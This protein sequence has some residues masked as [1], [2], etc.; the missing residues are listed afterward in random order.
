M[1]FKT[2]VRS[3]GASGGARLTEAIL[4]DAL[5]GACTDDAMSWRFIEAISRVRAL[6]QPGG[7]LGR[8][9]G[10]YHEDFCR[11]TQSGS[12][13]RRRLEA[14]RALLPAASW[15]EPPPFSLAAWRPNLVRMHC[16]TR[17]QR[18]HDEQTMLAIARYGPAY[19]LAWTDV[20]APLLPL[21]RI[22]L[23]A[24][25]PS[26]SALDASIEAA[27]QVARSVYGNLRIDRD[28]LDYSAPAA[29]W[30]SYATA[31]CEARFVEEPRP[32]PVVE[33]ASPVPDWE[34]EL[35]A[36]YGLCVE[37][38]ARFASE[39]PDQALAQL[40]F[41]CDPPADHVLVS[42]DT[43]D[44]FVPRRDSMEQA[45]LA[46]RR[47]QVAARGGWRTA[48]R[49]FGRVSQEAHDPGNFEHQFF[50]EHQVTGLDAYMQAGAAPPPREDN[51]ESYDRGKLRMLFFR[52]FDRMVTDGVLARYPSWRPFHLGY[53]FH[54]ET[55][56]I[57]FSLS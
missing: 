48:H 20:P 30:S 51:E 38:L 35:E 15:G 36:L 8:L 5:A 29:L 47:R 54:S 7:E 4:V 26:R 13:L 9:L 43:A 14:L 44:D 18:G 32:D 22:P 45:L 6:A 11:G 34:R 40:V 55:P 49:Y 17:S 56:V 42:L 28:A 46:R 57:L 53:A 41:D 3:A 27:L 1:G 24:P 52:V 21:L 39:H 37:S 33:V 10:V 19:L 12:E 2:R 50:A 31:L 16:D 25:S 23:D